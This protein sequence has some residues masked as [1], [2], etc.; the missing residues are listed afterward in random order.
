MKL[1]SLFFL[2]VGF[3]SI[4]AAYAWNDTGHMVIATIA[5]Q[6]LTARAKN[7]INWLLKQEDDEK[8][9]TFVTASVWAD[10]KRT[11]ESAPWHFI[12]IHFRT[13]GKET[14]NQP[15]KNNVVTAISKLSAIMVDGNQTMR[16]RVEALR[17]VIHFV[18]DIHQPLHAVARDSDEHPDG[19]R[20]GND[21]NIV[22][23]DAFAGEHEPKNLHALWD[24]GAGIFPYT[25]R[26]LTKEGKD[27]IEEIA[28][29]IRTRYPSLSLDNVAATDPM[30][31][32][33][34]SADI[35]KRIAYD[36]DLKEGAKP[37]NDYLK[38]AQDV[39]SQRAAYAGYRLAALLNK[40]FG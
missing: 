37:S 16:D 5:E 18:G 6:N 20:G 17:Y 13:D 8:Y 32:A 19:D 33:Q 36:E 28:Q 38:K 30:A 35:A 14:V 25:P 29:T 31:W 40:A 11:K 24:L 2:T 21:F 27:K 22:S 15:D 4:H 26:P 23:P 34:E 9:D 3:A 12:N 1:R 7:Q 39:C 10:D